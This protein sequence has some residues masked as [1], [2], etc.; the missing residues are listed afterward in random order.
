MQ[1]KEW[2]MGLARERG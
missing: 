2:K 1:T